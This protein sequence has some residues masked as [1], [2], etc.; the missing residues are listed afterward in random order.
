MGIKSAYRVSAA[1][2]TIPGLHELLSP[3]SEKAL[4]ILQAQA[5]PS[6]T[7]VMAPGHPKDLLGKDTAFWMF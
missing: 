4:G 7:Q 6:S 2:W 3:G 1:A 5:I